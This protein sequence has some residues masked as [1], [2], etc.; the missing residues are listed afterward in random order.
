M[1]D[2]PRYTNIRLEDDGP[3]TW[4]VLD[5]PDRANALSN[6]LL[7]EFSAALEWLRTGG[8]PIIGLRGEGRGFCAGYDM[9]QVADPRGAD[10]VSDRTRLQRNLN[11][12]LTMWEHPKPIIAAVHGY[13]IAGGSQLVTFTDIT[14]VAEDARIGEVTIPVGAGYVS[15][16]WATLV[17]P[18]RAKELAF[19]PGNWI[20]GPTAVEWGWANHAVPADQ[21]LTRVRQ[22]ADRMALIP[23]D[24]LTIKKFAINRA[25]DAMGTR[26]A[27]SAIADADALAHLTPGVAELRQRIADEGLKSVI[28][29]FRVPPT[30]TL[31]QETRD[32]GTAP[33]AR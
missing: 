17:G 16:V 1:S 12:Y 18:K 14:V 30:M 19:V 23:A 8:G 33:A 4:I 10:P 21:L 26:N 32:D 25:L 2:Y 11:R 31:S 13:C 22:L 28:E 5:R 29:S 27:V 24:M 6:E 15:P 7:D 3:L 9:G 20:D